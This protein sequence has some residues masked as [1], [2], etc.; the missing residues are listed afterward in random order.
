MLF[1]L[2]KVLYRRRES[3]P[4]DLLADIYTDFDQHRQ[5]N[6]DPKI[7]ALSTLVQDLLAEC[8]SDILLLYD[9]YFTTPMPASGNI[10]GVNEAIA[11][12]GFYETAPGV[13]QD[14]FTN[15]LVNELG[16]LL[17][18]TTPISV[19]E[20]YRRL[21]QC[22]RSNTL[23]ATFDDNRD[24]RLGLDGKPIFE[25]DR[26]RTPIF[27]PISNEQERRKILLAPLPSKK[28]G[29][30]PPKTGLEGTGET[31]PQT[32]S[33][34]DSEGGSVSDLQNPLLYPIVLLSIRVD[35]KNLETQ[36]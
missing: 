14:S 2:V 12:C 33:S 21:I 34:K 18:S 22:L 20:L 30:T 16:I 6:P 29:L 5:Q 15:A 11:A 28:S 13:G 1:V 23:C 24:I 8:E 31:L 9:C 17:Y 26:R 27:Y 19:G 35:S 25:G 7:F 3:R 4:L 32:G 10:C 36:T